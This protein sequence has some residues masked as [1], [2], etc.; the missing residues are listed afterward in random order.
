M[1][2]PKPARTGQASVAVFT[3]PEVRRPRRQGRDPF[4][5]LSASHSLHGSDYR[6][7]AANVGIRVRW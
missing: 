4:G 6:E 2:W 7:R 5:V 1:E 3:R